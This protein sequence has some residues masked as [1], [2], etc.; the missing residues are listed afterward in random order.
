MFEAEELFVVPEPAWSIEATSSPMTCIKYS[1]DGGRVA[2][3]NRPGV[4]TVVSSYDGSF[5]NSTQQNLSSY[6]VSGLSFH[7]SDSGI[8]LFSTKDGF[9]I[10]YNTVSNEIAHFERHLGSN[11]VSMVT[12]PFGDSFAIACADGSIRLYDFES[13][14]RTKALINMSG[15]SSSSQASSIHTI[16]Y[17]SEDSNIILSAVGNDRVLIWDI[18][19]GT[20]ERAIVGPHIRGDA[21]DMYDGQILT[22]S[23]RDK[24]QLEVWD[25]GTAKRIKEV[26]MDSGISGHD[27]LVTS[28]KMANNGMNLVAGG[29]GCN[30]AQAF[31]YTSGSFI[32]QTKSFATPV[33]CV[34][35]SPFGASFISASENGDASCY[36]IRLKP[37]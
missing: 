21:L 25:F 10:L 8:L 30:L 11:L 19:S 34:A 20:S 29:G 15:R 35:M 16:M 12:D 9:I 13:I 24:K 22:G 28:A 3:S 27:C 14:K 36:M 37:M 18:R 32:G 17:H 6:P 1:Q 7:P 2:Y 31:D 26:H 23:Y 33:S 4:V 5:Q